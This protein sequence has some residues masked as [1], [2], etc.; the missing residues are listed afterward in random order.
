M[1]RLKVKL[2]KSLID[3]KEEHKR[4]ARALG[5]R[6]V[7][8]VRVHNDTAVVRGMIYKIRHLVAVEEL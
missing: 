4:T 1:R 8:R 3:E 5:L 6:R 7:G 2:V